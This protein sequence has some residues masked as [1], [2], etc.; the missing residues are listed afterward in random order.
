ME[1]PSVT[2]VPSSAIVPECPYKTLP[3]RTVVPA[4]APLGPSIPHKRR[5]M[6]YSAGT[7]RVLTS[8]IWYS[9]RCSCHAN[10][11]HTPTSGCART[12]AR[13]RPMHSHA[14][15]RALHT[16]LPAHVRTCVPEPVRALPACLPAA[17][18]HATSFV[19]NSEMVVY[20]C[21]SCTRVRAC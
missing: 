6:G 18:F 17:L 16:D 2:T 7:R 20:A 3:R 13:T 5:C 4:A 1:C 8:S 19:T 14:C 12:V 15:T 9:R 10:A 21:H 11:R